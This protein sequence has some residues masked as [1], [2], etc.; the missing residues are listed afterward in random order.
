VLETAISCVEA[1]NPTVNAVVHKMYKAARPSP[2]ACLPARWRARPSPGGP[3]RGS[4][5]QSAAATSAAASLTRAG[6]PSPLEGALEPVGVTPTGVG[7]SE[8]SGVNLQ[9]GSTLHVEK[10]SA[11]AS[12][13]AWPSGD[14]SILPPP[15]ISP[16]TTA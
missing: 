15:L 7:A 1:I 6:R 3:S 8:G 10:L 5:P 11:R 12:K 9:V 13:A 16:A 4:R 2:R 14:S